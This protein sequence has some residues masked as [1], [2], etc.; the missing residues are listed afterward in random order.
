MLGCCRLAVVL[1]SVKEALGSHDRR[2]LRLQDLQGDLA[3]VLEVIG[4]VDR[5]HPALAEFALDVI[6]AFEG[7]VQAFDGV[8]HQASARRSRGAQHPIIRADDASGPG[9]STWRANR[10][11]ASLGI[12][13]PRAWPNAC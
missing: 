3:L 5:G 10:T 13:P 2:Q 11:D 4:Q 6:A 8:R 12:M 7:F 9:G 1:I